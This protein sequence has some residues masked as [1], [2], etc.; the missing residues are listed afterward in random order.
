MICLGRCWVKVIS[1]GEPLWCVSGR[2]TIFAAAL[3][4]LRVCLQAA[5]ANDPSAR[6]FHHRFGNRVF[7]NRALGASITLGQF[8]G[9]ACLVSFPSGLAPGQT[10]CVNGESPKETPPRGSY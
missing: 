7:I 8:A 2:P 5:P 3:V 4:W 9:A 1:A 10:H 6:H